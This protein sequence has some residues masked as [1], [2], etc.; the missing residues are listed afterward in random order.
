MQLSPASSADAELVQ[1]PREEWLEPVPDALALP[2]DADPSRQLMLR[3]SIRLAFVAALQHLPPR[4]RAA[5]LSTEV[6]GL[7][8]AEAAEC[9]DTSLASVNSAV[10]R[11]RAALAMQ[12]LGE[13][14]P[15]SA[16]QCELVDKYGVHVHLRSGWAPG[17]VANPL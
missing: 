9:L 7:S 16:V 14:G 15:L 2:T 10:Q 17:G 13:A 1:R 11:A 8:A 5:L 3:Q 4:Q 6:L 12:N